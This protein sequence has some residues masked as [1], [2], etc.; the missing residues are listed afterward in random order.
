M[1][2]TSVTLRARTLVLGVVVAVLVG[3][4]GHGLLTG[5]PARSSTRVAAAGSVAVGPTGERDGLLVGFAHTRA[6]A[7][8]AAATYVREGQRLFD[9]PA[10]ERDTALR[11]IAAD[12][13]ANGVVG[14]Q[15]AQ[16]AE[17]DGVAQRGQG[18]LTWMVSVL[19]TRLD[20]YTPG[21]AEVSLW[22]VGILS[23]NGLMAPLAEWTT[24]DDELVWE[25]GDWRL[26][27]ETQ[28]PGPAPIQDPNQIPTS[29]EPMVGGAERLCPVPG[30]RPRLK[31]CRGDHRRRLERVGLDLEPDRRWGRQHGLGPDDERPGRL[32][33][34]RHHLVRQRA[35]GFFDRSSTPNLAASWFSGAQSP[36]GVVAGLAI[37]LLLLFILV[38]LVQGLLAGEGVAVAGR[39]ARDVPLA[40]LGIVATIGVTEVLLGACDEIASAVLDG[41]GAG[42]QAKTVLQHLG[43]VGAFSGQSTFVVFLLGLV[44]VIAAFLLWIELLIRASL[45]YVLLALSPLAYA[46][47]VWPSARR[48]LH[49]LAELVLA[50]I[51]S[52]VV[53]AIALAV[54]ASAL[55]QGTSSPAVLPTGEAQLGTLLVGVIM[56]L[57]AA[58]LT[59]FLV[60]KLLPV[61]EAAAVAQ[62]I[63]RGP[64]RGARSAVMTT[65]W[66]TRLAGTGAAALSGGGAAAGV[67][68]PAAIRSGP[69]RQ[70]PLRRTPAPSHPAP[71]REAR[72]NRPVARR[73]LANTSS[74]S[75]PT[76]P[77]T[78][79]RELGTGADLAGRDP[80]PPPT[81][82]TP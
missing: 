68:A 11:S 77:P 37:T 23:I 70:V 10:G 15:Q 17:L 74:T 42:Q 33:H 26:W 57:L 21:R 56:F 51:L 82:G 28:V 49:R 54:A 19:A 55:T 58:S 39:L 29:P 73:D 48:I 40:I 71:G 72:C 32:G 7:I 4:A 66:V 47:F 44:A 43:S 2:G 50:L 65:A 31:P 62:G 80:E 38:A 16:L 76:R 61:F 75:T 35:V 22:R 1:A 78:A 5:T 3:A 6:G 24:V 63:S 36:Y 25:H 59:P 9:L 30:P 60:L 27:S 64:A 12:G 69:P 20:A 14:E 45:I 52:K 13:A 18:P 46:A 67:S 79:A 53:I 41:T 34:R 81:P 8:T